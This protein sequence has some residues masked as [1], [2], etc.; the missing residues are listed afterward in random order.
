MVPFWGISR[1]TGHSREKI[2]GKE[3]DFCHIQPQKMEDPIKY[4][5]QSIRELG[6]RPL[7]DQIQIYQLA[8]HPLPVETLPKMPGTRRYERWLRF[9]RSGRPGARQ[10]ILC[11]MARVEKAGGRLLTRELDLRKTV[12]LNFRAEVCAV[13]GCSPKAAADFVKRKCRAV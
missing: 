8:E 13:L 12:E 4:T 9:L 7:M 10:R 2:L 5:Y 1:V 3:C 11:E 6:I